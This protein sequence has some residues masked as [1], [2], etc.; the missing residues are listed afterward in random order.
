MTQAAPDLDAISRAGADFALRSRQE[1]DGAEQE[2]ERPAPLKTSAKPLSEADRIIREFRTIHLTES[3]SPSYLAPPHDHEAECAVLEALICGRRRPADLDC[4]APDFFHPL[5]QGIAAAVE[6]IVD[7]DLK[8][9]MVL[10]LRVIALHG[11]CPTRVGN[12]L[13]ELVFRTPA[14][15]DVDDLA[16]RIAKLAKRRRALALMQR[17]DTLWRAGEDA[18]DYLVAQ[19][20]QGLEDTRR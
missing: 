1:R 13:E 20:I 12:Y 17:V 5:H 4:K 19:L 2:A 16:E 15:V 18:N 7:R 10:V 3:P 14:R 6:A 8:P 9:G 11:A